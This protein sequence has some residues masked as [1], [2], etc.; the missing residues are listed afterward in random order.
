VTTA[1]RAPPGAGRRCSEEARGA[2]REEQL[3]QKREAGG[4]RLDA[5]RSARR[6]VEAALDLA[7]CSRRRAPR[8]MRAAS[9]DRSSIGRARVAHVVAAMTIVAPALV[10]GRRIR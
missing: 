1:R 7:R 2:R 6:T 5:R 4:S 8:S 9:A 10:N 3:A